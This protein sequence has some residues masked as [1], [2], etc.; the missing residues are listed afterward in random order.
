[1]LILLLLISHAGYAQSFK[2]L[3]FDEN[4]AGLHDSASTFYH[5]IKYTSL[6]AK[7]NVYVT[8]GGSARWEYV[9]FNNEDWGRLGTGHNNFLLQRYDL[10]ADVQ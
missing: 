9:D 10:H 6:S 7:S 1:M 4:Y 8:F 3:R 2:L 5:K